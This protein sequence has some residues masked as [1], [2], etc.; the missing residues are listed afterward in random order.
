MAT[1]ALTPDILVRAYAAGIFPMAESAE[2][3]NI[4]WVD[5]ERRGIIPLDQFHV[6]RRLRR[7]VRSG[8]FSIRCDTAFEQVIRG[9]ASP[10]ADRQRTWIN[11]EII[12]LYHALFEQ[13]LAHS[14]EAWQDGELVGGL[15]G[16]SLNAVF[17]GES[18]FSFRRDASKVALVHLVARLIQGGY[19]LLDTQ[20]VTDHLQSFGAIEIPRADYRRRLN[21]ALEQPALF[22]PLLEVDPVGVVLQASTQTS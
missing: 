8:A 11:E 1:P 7:T 9:C 2:D 19:T 6:P 15:Y 20:F 13:G 3:P 16:V 5:P 18:M 12:T 4:F 21:A 22:Q 17:F 10:A 14:V